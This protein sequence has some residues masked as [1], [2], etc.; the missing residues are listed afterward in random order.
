MTIDI[1]K[2]RPRARPTPARL[3]AATMTAGLV[4][5]WACG[6][7]SQG[8]DPCDPYRISV[9][10]SV[11]DDV[12]A[13]TFVA[14]EARANDLA[15]AA[16]AWANA[17][18]TGGDVDAARQATADAWNESMLVWQRAEMMQVGPAGSSAYVVGGADLRDEIYSWPTVNPCR[19]DEELVAESYSAEGFLDDA[20]VNLEGLDAIEYLVFH[21][22]A[23]NACDA[24]S[25]INADGTWDGL[26]A[27]EIERR[28]AAYTAVAAAG[29]RVHA[30]QLAAA[31][32]PGGEYADWLARAGDDDSPY[33]DPSAAV[34]DLMTAVLYL[35]ARVKDRK[36]AAT[37]VDGLESPFAARSKE[38]VLANLQGLRLL[39]LGGE[40]PDS[41]FGFDDFLEALEE[42]ELAAELIA[43]IDDAIAS[44][45][46]FDGSF[47]DAL[48]TDS[49][50]L[51]PVQ[52]KVQRLDD[53]LKGPVITTLKL[54][55]PGEGAGDG[56]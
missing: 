51:A 7:D 31:W 53:L 49:A 28:R 32:G 14:F 1:K 13:P 11:A 36:L 33:E 12:L 19:V 52:T 45:E 47:Q 56:D 41:G 44:V 26:E 10:Q 27:A 23:G 18:E 5:A 48:A 39:L 50:A 37:T 21:P 6:V 17:A 55:P 43:T 15:A 38:H 20:L 8:P 42:P 9:A 46:T 4:I 16:D 22:G 40:S 35:D 2:P 34:D 54:R 24:S 3:A 29:V 25:S 30:E